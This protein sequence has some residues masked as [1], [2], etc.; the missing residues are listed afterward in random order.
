MGSL[1]GYPQLGFMVGSLAGNALFPTKLPGQTGPKLTDARTTTANIGAP[2]MEVHGTDTVAGNV[3]WMGPPVET[4]NTESVGKGGPSQDYTTFSYTQSIAVGICRGPKQSI[5]R[6]WENGK[7]V[8]D[9]RAEGVPVAPPTEYSGGVI[10]ETLAQFLDRMAAAE[11]YRDTFTFYTGAEDQ[12]PDPTIELDKGVGNV[13]AF[14]GLAYVVF[15]NRQLREDQALRHPTF[16]FEMADVEGATGPTVSEEEFFT[17]GEHT[18]TKNP[19]ATFVEVCAVGG[20][21]AGRTPASGGNSN[22][23]GGGGGGRSVGRWAAG[24][25]PS[26]VQITVGVPGVQGSHDGGDSLFGAYLTG[27]GGQT[28]IQPGPGT[29]EVAAGGTSESVGDSS[30][31]TFPQ[32]ADG[33]AGGSFDEYI[34]NPTVGPG[35]PGAPGGGGAGGVYEALDTFT[36]LFEVRASKEGGIGG[37]DTDNPVPGGLPNGGD[38]D[39]NLD[40]PSGGGGGGGGQVYVDPEAEVLVVNGDQSPIWYH[41]SFSITGESGAGGRGGFPGGG[42]GGGGPGYYELI[43]DQGG[44]DYLGQSADLNY[45]VDISPGAGGM[46]GGGAVIVRQFFEGNGQGE[47]TCKSLGEIVAA[48]CARAGLTAADI[49]TTD[50]DGI[51]IHGY[52]VTRVMS[53]ADAI[54]PLRQVGFFDYQD[55]GEVLKFVARGGAI[56]YSIPSAMLGVVEGDTAMPPPKVKIREVMEKDLPR[57]LRLHYKAPSRD[58]EEGEQDSPSRSTSQAVQVLDLELPVAISDEMVAQIAEVLW[59]EAWEGRVSYEIQLD[60]YYADLLP[61]DVVEIPVEGFT[62]RARIIEMDEAAPLLRRLTLLRDFDGSYVSQATADAP[63]SQPGVITVYSQTDI[64]FLDLPALRAEDDNAGIYATVRPTDPAQSWRGG[65]IHRSLDSGASYAQVAG[66]TS[67]P[68]IGTVATP[69]G[70]GSSA[71]WD[72]SQM[73]TVELATGSLENRTEAAVL[74]GANVLAIGAPGRWEIAQF[75][76]CTQVGENTYEL[77]HWLRGR[78]GTEHHMGTMQAGDQVVL[79]SGAGIVRLPLDAAQIGTEIVYRA[80]T[81]GMAFATGLDENYTGAGV[82]LLPYSPVHLEVGDFAGGVTPITWIR[83][84]R[85]NATLG[86]AELPLSEA[87]EE[88]EVDI[89]DAG[90]VIHTATV[91]EPAYNY[92]GALPS[93]GTVRVYQI[94]AVVDRGTPGELDT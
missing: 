83:R 89:L 93:P 17:A 6:I 13:P 80:V 11:D 91:N 4:S 69:M 53:A 27:A 55:T 65:V 28:C 61:A 10:T 47:V 42:G 63:Q 1:V 3:M 25:L 81:I 7:L 8:Y 39:E 23:G 90:T 71:T 45:L 50:I 60:S 54:E 85:L 16:K 77:S 34:S 20:G 72:D 40:R 9:A 66:V 35:A 21:G 41:L 32:P 76:T 37:L 94:S 52:T 33:G 36:A 22:A 5:M 70:N 87:T 48:I 15:H 92:A 78:R 18:W 56:K 67:T 26:T 51:C 49:D 86:G 75:T 64:I 12:L 62:Q 59:A 31:F 57:V 74:L 73:L 30:Q 82:A 84:D 43:V 2:V 29:G 58:Y 44:F 24:D 79:V 14:R 19:A 46:G 38:G 68:T 88:Y